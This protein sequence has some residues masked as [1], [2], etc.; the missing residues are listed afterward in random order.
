MSCL[1][2]IIKAECAVVKLINWEQFKQIWS[3]PTRWLAH[4]AGHLRRSDGFRVVDRPI[5]WAIQADPGAS[6][7]SSGPSGKPIRRCPEMGKSRNQSL[8]RCA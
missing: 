7:R 3:C 2:K 8:T 1:T 6:I 5:Q 4:P